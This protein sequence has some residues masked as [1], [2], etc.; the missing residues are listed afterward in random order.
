MHRAGGTAVAFWA[1]MNRRLIATLVVGL[2]LSV[3]VMWDV[4]RD[5][6]AS[7]THP[8]HTQLTAH[9]PQQTAQR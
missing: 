3:A 7:T 4:A 6:I 5:A 1:V 9:T 8:H 2:L